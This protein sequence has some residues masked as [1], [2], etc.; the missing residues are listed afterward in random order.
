MFIFTK[1]RKVSQAWAD[2]REKKGKNEKFVAKENDRQEGVIEDFNKKRREFLKD[3]EEDTNKEANYTPS[4]SRVTKADSDQNRMKISSYAAQL[5]KYNISDGAGAALAT[6]LLEDLGMVTEKNRSLVFDRFKIRR[7]RQRVRSAKKKEKKA[8]LSGKIYC[9]GTDGKR[10]KHT[11]VI[12]EKE[13]N[14]NIVKSQAEVTEEHIVYTDPKNYITHSV[15]EEGQGDGASLGRDLVDVVREFDSQDSLE[16][17]VCDGTSVMTGCYNGMVA[18]AERELGRELQWSICQLHG[19]ECPMRHVFQELDG[20]FGTSGP[21]SFQGPLG[22]AIT[23]PDHHLKPVVRFAAVSSPDLPHLPDEIV[24]DLS[25]DQNLMYRYCVAVAK[26][27]VPD[28][29]AHQKPGGINHARWLTFGLTALIDYTR[30]PK[31]SAAK[32]KFV[33]YLQKVY[34]P[35]WFLIKTKPYIEHGARNTFSVMQLINKQPKKIQDVAKKCFQTNAFFAHGSNLLVA[36]LADERESVRQKAA[37]A[38]IRMR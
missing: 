2:T 38:I 31:P 8:D 1:D 25:R 11:K 15:I 34:V 3:Q 30:D 27:D 18:S 9:I 5:D 17:I 28:G 23:L 19:N 6:A 16:C 10:D 35:G 36:M 7:A 29:L 12:I 4:S 33:D 14:N 20:G 37:N 32:K 21:K 26:G 24:A 22:Q 13:I